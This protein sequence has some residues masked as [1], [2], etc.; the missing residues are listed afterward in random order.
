MPIFD[1][2]YQHW[3]GELTGH[4]WRWLAITRHG[5]RI[6]M[7]NTLLR[8]MLLLAWLPAIA[9]TIA[10][11]VWGLIEQKSKLIEPILSYLDFLGPQIL[12]DPKAYRVEAWTLCYE[13]FLAWE[14][15]F[16]M[17]L[18]LIVGPSLI[19]QDIRFNAL[20]LYFSRPLR[21]SDYFVG[22]LGIIG[23]FL[24]MVMVAPSVVAYAVGMLFSM[25]I[26]II[27]ETLPILLAAVAY[28][29]VVVVSAG[30]LMLALSTLS[31]N[32]RYVGLF[33]AGVWL[34][35][36]ITGSVLEQASRQERMHA[37][38]QKTMQE[39]RANFK[40]NQKMTTE[41]AQRQHQAI[42][43][44]HLE[45][46]RE[47]F[48][49]AKSDW[50]PLLSYTANLTRIGDTLLRKESCWEKLSLLVPEDQRGAYM[51][52]NMEMLYPWQWSAIVL[53]VLFGI[54]ICI[55][56]FRVKSLDRLR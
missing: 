6:G 26:S 24:G 21:R 19:S 35:T 42:V 27:P 41:Q 31:R 36:S 16:S 20:P 52:Q 9:L 2:G 50:R 29:A 51:L 55:L 38:Y 40:Q 39:E 15:R 8:I 10:L 23:A 25:D 17:L 49:Q 13:N 43:N 45:I 28:G 18:I 33:W 30:L 56:N 34:V 11:V 5:V 3:T 14:L 44:A 7:K 46:Q 53:I 4:T 37:K 47:E 32:S 1:Q 22:K 54:S 12:N 48:E